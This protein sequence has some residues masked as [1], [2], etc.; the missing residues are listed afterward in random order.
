MGGLVGERGVIR[1]AFAAFERGENGRGDGAGGIAAGG[2]VH[3]GDDHPGKSGGRAARA[4]DL[5]R[6]DKPAQGEALAG[7]AAADERER[8]RR[9]GLAREAKLGERPH[10]L[11][12]AP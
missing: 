8:E 2:G 12:G 1:A 4:S 7:A 9:L 10:R 6:L 5:D 3:L 11:G